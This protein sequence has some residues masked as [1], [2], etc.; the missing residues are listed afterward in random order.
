MGNVQN[1]YTYLIELNLFSQNLISYK[2]AEATERYQL[3]IEPTL[4][5]IKRIDRA[6][7]AISLNTKM[8]MSVK[9]QKNLLSDINMAKAAVAEDLVSCEK[10]NATN[11]PQ[12]L[13]QLSTQL[14]RLQEL[15]LYIRG[16]ES[17]S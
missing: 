17:A 16:L 1:I 8:N 4:K 11:K 15:E 5:Y 14:N 12:I 3:D 9:V 7:Q 2:L 10:F 6:W 13:S